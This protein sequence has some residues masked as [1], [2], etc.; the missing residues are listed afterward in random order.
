MIKKILPHLIAIGIFLLLTFAYFSPLLEGKRLEQHDIAQWLGMSKEITDYRN[1]SGEEPLW[2]N[3]MFGGMPA[4]Q[5]SVLYPANLM[6]YVNSVL[7]FG[8]PVPANYLF[9]SFIGMY[10]LLLVLRFDFRMAIAGACVL[11]LSSYFMIVIMAGHNSKAHAIALM[12]F[13]LAG[14]LLTL[15]GKYLFGAALTAIALALQLYAN[16]LQIS[17]YLFFII[18]CL[19]IFELY[20]AIKE[21]TISHYV[22]ASVCLLFAAVLSVLPNL[23]S[24][25]ATYEYGK[26]TTR[27][28]SELTEK[29]V[30]SGLDKDYALSWSY[31]I[32]ESLTLLVPNFMGGASQEELSESSETY[33]AMQKNGAGSQA[34]SFIKNAPTYWGTQPVTAGPTYIGASLLFLFVLGMFLV[35]G[36]WKWWLVTVSVLGLMLSWGRN[37]TPLT[38]LFF[39][40]VP[41]YNKFRAVSMTLVIVMLT[42]PLLGF[43]GLKEFLNKSQPIAQVK[44]SLLSA[45]YITGGLCLFLVLGGSVLFSFSGPVDAN[46]ESY[47]WL[48]TALIADRVTMMRI[49]AV[50]SLFFIVACFATLW[51]YL[52]S[53][54]NTQTLYVLLGLIFIIDLLPVSKRYLNND[55]FTSKSNAEQPFKPSNA[56]LQILSDPDPNFRVMNT[57]VSTFND[58]STSYFHK[59]IGGYHGAKLKRY[60]ELIEYQISKNNVQVLNMLNT[61]YFILRPSEGAEPIAQINPDA[62]GHAWFVNQVRVVNN[63]DEEIAALSD[64]NPKQLAVVDQRFKSS[65]TTN[66][67]GIDSLSSITLESYAPNRIKYNAVCNSKSFVVFS[68]IYYDKGWQV[69]LDGNKSEYVRVN[70]VLRGMELPSGKHSIEFKFEPVV[71]ARGEQISLAGSVLLILIFAG[72]LVIEIRK[73]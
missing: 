57:T 43:L 54:I 28:P 10:L 23:T 69:Y 51:Y 61:K 53:K 11:G 45:L 65:I 16:H 18:F 32:D 50:R 29:K 47:Q 56:D 9:L 3:S 70:Y 39:E 7:W 62:L 59:S 72:A 2:T 64:F 17:Y 14:V 30:S 5:I 35:K 44:K 20:K 6:S 1:N 58:A 12:P 63:A 25:W 19:M 15:R 68:E 40:F 48:K 8:M 67:Y 66:D 42:I 33:K 26:D 55:N 21:K 4:Y 49:D 24:I 31:G 37:F 41:G 52:K 60:Q 36:P 46:F 27:G 13:V 22:K 38:D 73:A 34:R 71:Y